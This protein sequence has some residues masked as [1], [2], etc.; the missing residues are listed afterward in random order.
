MIHYLSPAEVYA[1][2]EE[3]V[4]RRPMV[5]DRRLLISAMARPMN[6]AFGHEAY[7]TLMDKAAAILHSLAAHHLFGDGNKRTATLATIKFLHENGL[8][9]TW[10]DDEVYDFV[11]EVAKGEHDVPDIAVWLEAHTSK[12]D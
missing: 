4:G 7:P 5:R 3:V 9:A 6:A 12:T 8:D 11:L 2:N 1:I 10:D